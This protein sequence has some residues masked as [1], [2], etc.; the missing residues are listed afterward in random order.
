LNSLLHSFLGEKYIYGFAHIFWGND[1][2]FVTIKSI[3]KTY[4]NIKMIFQ[5]SVT[6]S[7]LV[8]KLWMVFFLKTH[9]TQN[10]VA[11]NTLKTWGKKIVVKLNIKP[12][13]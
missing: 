7:T 12:I 6:S 5:D 3:V 2:K 13:C 4:F 10:L 9:L 8:L 1:T 11:M